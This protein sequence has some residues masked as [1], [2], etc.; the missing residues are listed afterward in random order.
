MCISE[1]F[2]ATTKATSGRLV[3]SPALYQIKSAIPRL[4]VSFRCQG[5]PGRSNRGDSVGLRL[6]S[7]KMA[8]VWRWA[9]G[10]VP[11][12][13]SIAGEE[14]RCAATV[15][16]HLVHPVAVLGLFVWGG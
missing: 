8:D 1:N 15:E 14:Q 2:S 12:P 13:S 7:V 11:E 10:R 6:Q 4:L 3:Y 5:F 16:E 9:D